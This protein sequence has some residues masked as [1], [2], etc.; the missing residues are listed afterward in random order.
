MGEAGKARW[1]KSKRGSVPRAY[2][3]A[4]MDIATIL[5]FIMGFAFIIAAIVHDGSLK[6]FIDL[7]GAMVAFGGSTS[8][9]LI[10]FPMKK[11]LGTF[12]V[13]KNCFLFKLPEPMDE[14]RR[15]SELA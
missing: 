2:E 4:S 9:I 3:G 12:A 14:I 7:P 6:S 1:T 5:G 15:L 10:M 13:V 11:A 8:A